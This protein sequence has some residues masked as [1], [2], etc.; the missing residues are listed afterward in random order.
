M[1]NLE[2]CGGSSHVDVV[3]LRM[4]LMQ[5][6]VKEFSSVGGIILAHINLVPEI[7]ISSDSSNMDKTCTMA[8]KP[9]GH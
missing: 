6:I 8:W 7:S 5:L 4:S 2:V 9:T 1:N 3:E